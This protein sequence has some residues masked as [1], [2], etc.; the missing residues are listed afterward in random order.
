MAAVSS[1]GRMGGYDPR[2]HLIFWLPSAI[3]GAFD[4]PRLP[5]TIHDVWSF[6]GHKSVERWSFMVRFVLCSNNGARRAKDR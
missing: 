1:V 3:D 2:L 4:S 6:Q 5:S